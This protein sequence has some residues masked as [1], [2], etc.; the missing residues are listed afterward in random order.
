MVCP[1][2]HRRKW[3]S[4]NSNP[5]WR[6][7]NP[8]CLNPGHR[9]PTEEKRCY[10]QLRIHPALLFS[11]FPH[12]WSLQTHTGAQQAHLRIAL[13]ARTTLPARGAYVEPHK[14]PGLRLMVFKSSSLDQLPLLM[15]LNSTFCPIPC[16]LSHHGT[17]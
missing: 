6:A 12:S 13:G 9:V 5:D 4:Q 10:P 1:A 17:L 11:Q 3:N 2:F 16:E 7:L 15:L 14:A 8:V